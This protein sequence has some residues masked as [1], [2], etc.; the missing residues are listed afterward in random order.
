MTAQQKLLFQIDLRHHICVGLDTDLKKLP[1]EFSGRNDAIFAFNRAIVDATIKDTAAYKLNFAF[2]EA[3]DSLG[4]NALKETV[5]YIKKT[6]EKVLLIGD[7]K[8]GDIGNTSKMYAE[9]IFNNFGFDSS[10][11][12]PYMGKDSLDPFFDFQDKINFILILTSNSGSSDFEKQALNS[13][14]P[15]Y[16]E[17]L[18]KIKEWFPPDQLGTVFGATNINNLE[19]DIKDLFGTTVLVPGVGAQGGDAFDVSKLFFEMKH[20]K[21]LINSSRNII[22]ASKNNDFDLCANQELIK[23]NLDIERAFSSTLDTYRIA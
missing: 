18:R 20:N 3:H 21:F 11:L 19:K 9:A 10:T 5:D 16:K 22:Y 12:A 13:G 14:L 15:L 1:T 6:D 17:V 8:R 2:Y 7:A 23:L 4:M